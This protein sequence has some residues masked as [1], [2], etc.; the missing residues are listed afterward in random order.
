MGQKSFLTTTNISGFK[1]FFGEYEW[2]HQN[3]KTSFWGI[4]A[5]IRNSRPKGKEPEN[6]FKLRK[7]LAKQLGIMVKNIRIYPTIG[8]PLEDRGIVAFAD[9]S[10]PKRRTIT[11]GVQGALRN[12][13]WAHVLC[14]EGI[15]RYQLCEKIVY[16]IKK[17]NG[18]S[19]KRK[20]KNHSFFRIHK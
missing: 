2:W 7:F 17:M 4:V 12:G 6:I 20:Y 14:K 16:R 3:G 5:S 15:N 8:T 19:K 13:T 11:I 1:N 10:K 9:I 18:Y